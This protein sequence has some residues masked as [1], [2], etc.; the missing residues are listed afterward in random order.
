ME[1]EK[2]IKI[3]VENNRKKL[4]ALLQGSFKVCYY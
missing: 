2:S 3:V 1:A 4:T